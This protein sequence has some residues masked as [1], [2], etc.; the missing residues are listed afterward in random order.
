MVFLQF[1]NMC[2]KQNNT[3]I[4]GEDI[5]KFD[6][7]CHQLLAVPYFKHFV[8]YSSPEKNILDIKN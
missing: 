5:S 2:S 6:S 3:I 8:I 7:L 4:Q 1:T